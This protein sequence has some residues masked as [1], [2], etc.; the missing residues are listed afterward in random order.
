MS[1][2]L[3]PGRS[4]LRP[5]LSVGVS[6][7]CTTSRGDKRETTAWSG[8]GDRRRRP[9]SLTHKQ[10]CPF[11]RATAPEKEALAP[12]APP[13]RLWKPTARARKQPALSARD[14]TITINL[15]SSQ[16]RRQT[17]CRLDSVTRSGWGRP[18]TGVGSRGR[19]GGGAAGGPSGRLEHL[20]FLGWAP[21]RLQAG[22]TAAGARYQ[23]KVSSNCSRRGRGDG[24]LPV[25]A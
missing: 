23:M 12:P 25:L 2:G 19:W 21:L 18:G 15:G 20:A 3:A 4:P 22:A 1:P 6:P 13:A 10:K 14:K 5:L 11:I 16:A 17:L 7:V 24:G 8:A 9:E